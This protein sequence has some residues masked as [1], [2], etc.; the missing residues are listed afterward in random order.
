MIFVDDMRNVVRNKKWPYNKACHLVADT[1]DELHT[2]A[3]RLRLKRVWFQAGTLPHY[4]LTG[5]KRK[6]AVMLGAEAISDK[7]L[8]EMIRGY[9]LKGE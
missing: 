5:S 9:R 7:R 1:T 4:D 3:R 6:M 8:A 2:F